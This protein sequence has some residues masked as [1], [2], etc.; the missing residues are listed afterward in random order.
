MMMID[1]E[2]A[3]KLLHNILYSCTQWYVDM[4]QAKLPT[5]QL[6]KPVINRGVGK[7]ATLSPM[8]GVGSQIH[9]RKVNGEY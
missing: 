8:R 3:L 6:A 1:D 5:L 4:R 2:A 7:I 9:R